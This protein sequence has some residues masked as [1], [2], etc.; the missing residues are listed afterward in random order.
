MT[1]RDIGGCGVQSWGTT[2]YG[3]DVQQ[4]EVTYY[5]Y[6]EV[7]NRTAALDPLARA[8]YYSYN[9]ASRLTA[10]LNAADE[11]AYFAY[12]LVGNRMAE[13]D[14]R[15]KVTYYVYDEPVLLPCARQGPS[16]NAGEG[17]GRRESRLGYRHPSARCDRS[18]GGALRI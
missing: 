12:D 10:T 1:E 13:V 2:R 4:E 18:L 15:E 3:G 16:G 8:T 14:G 6:D 5:T 11:A 7:G 17:N 9:A